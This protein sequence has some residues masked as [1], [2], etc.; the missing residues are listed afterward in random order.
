[1]PVDLFYE[2]VG[3]GPCHLLFVHGWIS[4]CRMW[5]DVRDRLDTTLW[6]QHRFDFRGCGRSPRT[7]L[8]HDLTGYADDLRAMLMRI[9]H[10]LTIVAHSMGAKVAQFVATEKPSNLERMILVAPGTAHSAK[11]NAKHRALTEA[12]F[13]SRRRIEAFQRGAMAVEIPRTAM[14]RLVEDA[15]SA[16]R[17]HWFGWYDV[18]RQ[19]EFSDRLPAIDVPVLA[20]A[21]AKDPLAPPSVV[22][23]DVAGAIHGAAFAMLRECGHNIP[24]EKPH[25]VIE[26]IRRFI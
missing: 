9:E 19:A 2:R 1:M 12:A 11:T 15:L 14:E 7:L 26:A 13:G 5:D 4:S 6:T 21:G 8:G 20:V 18:G 16:Q 22:K 10:P 17:E 24:V 23:R 3:D 25:D